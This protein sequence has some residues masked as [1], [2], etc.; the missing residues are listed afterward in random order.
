[1][2][3]EGAGYEHTALESCERSAVATL[4]KE[5]GM[6]TASGMGLDWIIANAVR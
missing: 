2:G 3:V 1:M 5:G 4:V 6:A